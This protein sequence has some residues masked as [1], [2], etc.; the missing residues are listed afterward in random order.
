MYEEIY[1]LEVLNK[2]K[3]KEIAELREIKTFQENTK[4]RF[5]CRLPLAKKFTVCQCS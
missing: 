1:V 5:C 4:E 2:A 3:L